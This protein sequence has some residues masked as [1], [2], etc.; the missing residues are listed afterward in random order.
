MMEVEFGIIC[1]VLV[2]AVTSDIQ[3]HGI[4]RK[5][6]EQ[7][8]GT[9]LTGRDIRFCVDKKVIIPLKGN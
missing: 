9:Y 7:D 6:C 2:L 5:Q 8:G 3:R 1:V 4:E